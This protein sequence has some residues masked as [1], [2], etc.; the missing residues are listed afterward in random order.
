MAGLIPAFFVA[1][2]DS[3]PPPELFRED[4]GFT[5]AE[6]HLQCRSKL[7]TICNCPDKA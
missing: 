7:W 5:R 4:K 3:T 6:R 2:T 1:K